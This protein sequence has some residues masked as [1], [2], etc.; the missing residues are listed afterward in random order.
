M[1]SV[2]DNREK[3]L[4]SYLDGDLAPEQAAEFAALLENEPGARANLLRF[5]L[6]ETQLTE[7]LLEPRRR[8]AR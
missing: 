7:A 8:P 4:E 1:S 3:L 2:N 6:L 5:V